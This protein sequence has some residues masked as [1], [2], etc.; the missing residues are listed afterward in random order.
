ME[1]NVT[2]AL[3]ASLSSHHSEADIDLYD[4][5]NFLILSLLS[6]L[7]V[8]KPL[9]IKSFVAAPL[10][11]CNSGSIFFYMVLGDHL[12]VLM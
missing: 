10:S 12:I 3:K 7:V 4:D 8:L 6:E 11:Q 9:F 2:A 1:K 5:A